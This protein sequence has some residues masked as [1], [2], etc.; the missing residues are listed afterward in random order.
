METLVVVAQHRS[1]YVRNNRSHNI[2]DRFGSPSP[3]KGFR[4]INCR[5]FQ[6]GVGILPSP[7]Q[8]PGKT[9]TK[10]FYYSEPPK[11]SKKTEPIPILTKPT[12]KAVS[13]ED[14]FASS[15]LW[16]GP[17]YSNSPPPS[18]LPMPK[19]SLRQKRTMSLELPP[20]EREIT[21]GSKSAPAS[22]TRD[23]EFLNRTVS[24]TKDLRR[25]LNLDISDD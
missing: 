12:M 9:Q 20:P 4:G 18:S 11:K 24:A 6:S 19:F 2:V 22:P 5:A 3:S 8:K 15:E 23:F 13:F 7:P 25:I 10:S 21:A 17:T 14:E 16:A 1:Q